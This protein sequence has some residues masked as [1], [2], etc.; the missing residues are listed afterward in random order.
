MKW[1]SKKTYKYTKQ[2][3]FVWKQ[4]MMCKPMNFA[5]AFL[6][7]QSVSQPTAELLSE[8]ELY[9]ANLGVKYLGLD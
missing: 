4:W 9:A 7:T 8:Q 3:L 6:A 5:G 1:A 2:M